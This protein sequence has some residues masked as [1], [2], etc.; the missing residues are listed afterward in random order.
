MKCE[1]NYYICLISKN[2]NNFHFH[3]QKCFFACNTA[4]IQ[5]ITYIFETKMGEGVPTQ[6]IHGVQ[7]LLSIHYNA[8]TVNS[9]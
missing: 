1:D 8:W 2:I 7:C 4:M 9:H 5:A 3:F 6:V